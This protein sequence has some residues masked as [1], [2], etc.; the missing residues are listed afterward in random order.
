MQR[1]ISIQPIVDVPGRGDVNAFKISFVADSPT[2]ARDVTGTLTALLIG[3]NLKT[4]E[5]HSTNTTKFLQNQVEAKKSAM[6]RQ[7]QLLRD[8]KMR[9]IGE[10]PEQQQGNLGILN[11]L[12]TQLQNATAALARSQQQRVYLESLLNMSK[13]Q[14]PSGPSAV[15][16]PATPLEAAEA[17]LRR[18]QSARVALLGRYTTEHPDVLAMDRDI[19]KAQDTVNRLKATPLASQTEAPADGA[20]PSRETAEDAS[21]VQ[22]RSQL[23]ANRVEMENIAKDE[24]RLTASIAEYQGRLN[25]TPIREQ[26]LSGITRDTDLLRQEYA[27]LQKKA[28]DSQLATD[29]EKSQSGQQFR[30]V[31][32]PSLPTTPSSPKRMK[33]SAA[34]TA[35]GLFLGLAL[36]FL[37]DMR[38]TSFH[39]EEAL[40]QNVTPPFLVSIPLLLTP[41]ERRAQGWRTVIEGVAGCLFVLLVAVSDFYLL[42]RR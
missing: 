41:S 4:R 39:S 36:A 33:M 32:A 28:G 40:L 8:F 20:S 13:R 18:L 7:E 9:H 2:L 6:D 34:G 12:Q 24:A 17:E 27:E 1:D 5:E 42:H 16:R 35:F 25:Q 10:L 26:E 23:E 38:D 29:L 3:E 21:I 22:I 37:I 11:A 15:A 14:L 19:S 31:D 30:L